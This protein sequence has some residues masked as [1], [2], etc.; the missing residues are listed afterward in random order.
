MVLTLGAVK[1]C[2]VAARHATNVPSMPYGVKKLCKLRVNLRVKHNTTDE[3]MRIS[4]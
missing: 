4:L 1:A 2:A 3:M